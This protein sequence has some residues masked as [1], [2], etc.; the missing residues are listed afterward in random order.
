M[1]HS[2]SLPADVADT[3]LVLYS[4][5]YDGE[6]PARLSH[7]RQF[8]AAT[9]ESSPNSAPILKSRS[10]LK[11]VVLLTF[12]LLQTNHGRTGTQTNSNRALNGIASWSTTNTSSRK[13]KHFISNRKSMLEVDKNTKAHKPLERH[14]TA[15]GGGRISR[16]L[17]EQWNWLKPG[18]WHTFPRPL[19][20][21]PI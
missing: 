13:Q 12:P 1:F 7:R 14:P 17:V 16:P 10:C 19:P 5:C 21:G 2:T 6:Y 11:A 20:R 15:S 8:A 18:E 4:L 9:S 3:H